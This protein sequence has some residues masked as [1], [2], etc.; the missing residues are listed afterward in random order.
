VPN[1]IAHKRTFRNPRHPCAG[2]WGESSTNMLGSS[3]GTTF[4]A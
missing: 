4:L 3:L 2:I 1:E